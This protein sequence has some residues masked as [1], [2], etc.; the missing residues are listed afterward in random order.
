[1]DPV[2]SSIDPVSSSLHTT[3]YVSRTSSEMVGTIG[4]DMDPLPKNYIG[5]I[6]FHRH[7]YFYDTIVTKIDLFVRNTNT[8]LEGVLRYANRLITRAGILAPL[9]ID[10]PRP[11][12]MEDIPNT[13]TLSHIAASRT[14]SSD[15]DANPRAMDAVPFLADPRTMNPRTT[16]SDMVTASRTSSKDV[17]AKDISDTMT[18]T[19]MDPISSSRTTKY[20]PHNVP[21]SATTLRGSST[22]IIL[23]N[24]TKN[25]AIAD[26]S[27]AVP[28]ATARTDPP[29]I[30]RPPIS[31]SVLR[32]A[33]LSI[34]RAPQFWITRSMIRLPILR[35]PSFHVPRQGW[36]RRIPSLAVCYRVLPKMIQS[37][38]PTQHGILFLLPMI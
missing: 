4:T 29:D 24:T 1:M 26:P 3:T 19:D 36:I 6:S 5:R 22:T 38:L 7:R 12:V 34:L 8:T 27:R 32:E 2:P 23:P 18:E 30:H 31:S 11:T 17:A 20:A 21:R 14:S 25:D 16:S 33:R 37:N 13:G 10:D 28:R 9:S 35:A 15:T